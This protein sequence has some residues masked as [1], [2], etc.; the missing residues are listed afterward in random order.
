MASLTVALLLVSMFYITSWSG[1]ETLD[2]NSSLNANEVRYMRGVYGENEPDEYLLGTTQSNVVQMSEPMASGGTHYWGMRVWIR[3]GT[4]IETEVTGGEA[5]A[6]VMRN[7][8]GQGIQS[9]EWDCPDIELSTTDSLVIRIYQERNASPPTTLVATF[10]T[11]HLGATGLDAATWTVHYHTHR[12]PGQNRFNWGTETYN[13]RVEG[14]TYEAYGVNVIEPEDAAETE[15]GT[16]DYSFTVE[17]TG[18]TDDTYDLTVGSDN[19]DFTVSTQEQVTISAGD[20]SDIE[21]QVTIEETAEVGDG[22]LVTL[23]ARSRNSDAEDS[24][25]F[26]LTFMTFDVDRI[27]IEPSEET[28]ST[29]E[30]VTYTA[31]AYDQ[32]GNV[33]GDVTEETTWSIDPGAGGRWQENV[34]TSEY[35]GTW[36]VTGTYDGFFDTGTLVVEEDDVPPTPGII[37]DYWWLLLLGAIAAGIFIIL[38]KRRKPF[39]EQAFLIY[40]DGLL[41][42]HA[43]SR[44]MPRMDSDVFSGMLTAIQNFVKDSFVDEM[45]W[46][47]KK[48]EFGDHKIAIERDKTGLLILALV[49]TGKGSE[50]VLSKMSGEILEEINDTY[51][52]VLSDWDG[53]MDNLRGIKDILMKHLSKR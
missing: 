12:A 37:R 53:D 15:T 42:T 38:K 46:G 47:L 22:A 16:Y 17:N 20:H 14:F 35:P 45:N 48:L 41:L 5:V 50:A 3:S 36:T 7:E 21:V 32:H 52:D 6:V 19:A 18:E 9:E 28:V 23:T 49:Y 26:R 31:T 34:Y 33:L 4:G 30:S 29:G 11:T 25:G 8:E 43:T 1:G 44:L 2:P 51:G 10:D 39:V 27:A 24:D 40:D 13:S